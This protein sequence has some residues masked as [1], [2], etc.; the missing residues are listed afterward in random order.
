[1]ECFSNFDGLASCDEDEEGLEE[2]DL[3]CYPY[4][5]DYQDYQL[6]SIP[7]DGCEISRGQ[8][9]DLSDFLFDKIN[10]EN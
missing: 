4:T 10:S 9:I 3:A 2:K 6:A 7:S 8:L 1:M 5:D